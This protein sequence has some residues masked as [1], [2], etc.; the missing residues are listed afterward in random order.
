MERFLLVSLCGAAGDYFHWP[1]S[2]NEKERICT[3][4]VVVRVF[5]VEDPVLFRVG[6]L[7]VNISSED[8]NVKF[9]PVHFLIKNIIHIPIEE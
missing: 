9:T 2:H 1:P 6:I 5:R 4:L 7:G 3:V 8:D